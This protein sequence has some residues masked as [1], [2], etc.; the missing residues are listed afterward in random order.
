MANEGLPKHIADL[1]Y[2]N[3]HSLFNDRLG[4]AVLR[5]INLGVA[6]EFEYGILQ[7]RVLKDRIRQL[8]GPPFRNP[9]ATRGNLVLGQDFEE[10]AIRCPAQYFNEHA[11]TVATTGSGKT[12]RSR[13][14]I[15]Q[16][17][18]LLSGL[19]CFDFRKREYAILKPY[20]ERVGVELIVVPAR[21]MRINPL[22]VPRYT[23]PRNYASIMA[24]GLVGVLDLPAKAARLL[25]LIILE[26]YRQFSVLDGGQNY[27]TLFDVREAAAADKGAHAESRRAIVTSLNPILVS[28]GEVLRYRFAW[29]SEDLAGLHLAFDLS[30]I[31]DIE[32]NLLLNALLLREFRSRLDRGISNPKMDLLVVCDE[33]AR[34]CSSGDSSVTDLIGAIRGTGIGLDLSVQSADL[35]RSILSNTPN[36]FLGRCASANDYDTI[37]AAMGL[38]TDQRRWLTTNLIPGMFVGCLGQGQALRRPFLFRVPDLRFNRRNGQDQRASNHVSHLFPANHNPFEQ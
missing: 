33:A 30:G 28:L 8:L 24:D 6:R 32:Q 7:S 5:S 27:P 31:T 35:T 26:L 4:K 14:H 13:F 16:M 25:H 9:G 11:L 19:W 17:A 36:K 10:N 23:D 22:H 29:T 1:I 2:A 20:L 37:G 34:L 21:Q 18:C 3:E 38:T 15:L 12:T